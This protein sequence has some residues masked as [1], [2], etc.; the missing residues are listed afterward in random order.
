MSTSQ[1]DKFKQ[2]ALDLGTDYSEKQFDQAGQDCEAEVKVA[3][4]KAQ[5]Y[6]S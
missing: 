5:G 2:A 3:R 4:E 6:W 1:L